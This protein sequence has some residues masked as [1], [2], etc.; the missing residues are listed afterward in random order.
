MSVYKRYIDKNLSTEKLAV[1]EQADRIIQEYEGAGFSLTLRQLFYQFVS[2]GLLPN[3]DKIYQWLGDVIS[4]GRLLGLLSWTAIEDRGRRLMG[5][6]TWESP[7]AAIREV[8]QSYKIDKWSNQPFR[9]EVWVEKDALS[10]VISPICN[11]LCVN[12]FASKGYNSQSAQWR[13]GER[14]ANYINKGQRPI[15]FYLGDHDPS[16]I[17]MTRDNQERLSMFAGVQIQVVRLA[18]N[19]DQ[20]K[21]YNPPPNPTKLSDSRS[22]T[23]LE[24]YGDNSWELDAL[25]PK[26]IRNII[27]TAVLKIRDESLWDEALL[28]EARHIEMLELMESEAE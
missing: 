7:A 8:R 1:I 11:E 12:F 20:V 14:L 27:S 6:Q 5:L 10:G 21:R 28:T 16:G 26:V 17:D 25:D 4:D 2:R 15:V 24:A 13:A 9:P 23:Y 3:T 19:M 18:L 22:T